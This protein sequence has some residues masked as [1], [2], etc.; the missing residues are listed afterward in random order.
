MRVVSTLPSA[1]EICYALGVEPVGVSHECD[2]PPEATA[3]R[4]V[5]RVTIDP[6]QDTAGINDQLDAADGPVYTIDDAALRE[7]DPDLIVTQG[8][9]DVCAVDRVLVEEAVDRVGLDCEI[10]TTDPHSLDDLFADVERIGAA[11]DRADRAADLVADLRARVDAVRDRAAEA[12]SRPRLAVLDW[13]DPVLVAGHWIPEMAE[14]AG[15]TYEMTDAGARSEP[16]E[17]DEV[18]AYDP[19]VL[20]LAPCGFGID[21]TV[22]NLAAVTDRPGWSNLTAVQEGRVFVMDG[23]HY[24]NRPGPRLVDTLE[25]LAA[26]VHPDLFEQP[27]AEAVRPVAA[28]DAP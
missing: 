24:V 5:N 13:L 17:W 19:E 15:A 18:V 1:T 22:A 7:A 16:R 10:L 26:L 12:E 21:Q 23:H 28:T 9:C 25:Y 11:M 27:P 4:S 8:I 20:V 2:Y 3:V 6:E 14:M